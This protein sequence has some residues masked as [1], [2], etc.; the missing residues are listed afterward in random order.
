MAHRYK[1][2]DIAQ[3]SGL[4][5]ATVDR[6]LNG[7]A[8]VRESTRAE[9]MQAI[10]DLD[11]QRSQLRLNGQRY[12]ID[13]VMEAPGRFS[14]AFRAAV[15][16]ELP[17]FAPA[18]LR[19]RFHLWEHGPPARMV[20]TLGR[21]RASH[22]VVLKAR[23]EPVVAEAIDAL[24]ASGVPVVTYTT[25]VPNSCRCAYVGIDNRAAG[26]TA[27][28]LVQQ[29][30]GPAPSDVL[31]ILSRNASRGEEE[32]EAGFRTG[33][34]G[35]GRDI[36]SVSDAG[37]SVNHDLLRLLEER[38]SLQAVYSI[39]G[40]NAATLAAFERLGLRCRVF[41]AHDLDA[42][43]R[44]LLRAGRISAVL[45]NDLCVDAR[46]AMQLILQAR[47]VLSAE[48]ARPTPVQIVCPHNLP[49]DR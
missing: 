41:V 6:V 26:V 4:S 9:V 25:D 38:P 10:A 48:P 7:R 23:D 19:A 3:Q 36:V 42:D 39:G 49:A 22:G 2:R 17:T 33:L 37:G 1:I 27:A 28:Y 8:G 20:E 14:D 35:S 12:L 15:E 31:V 24:A 44:R 18:V 34:R 45:H 21:I 47:G 5:K 16:Y 30:L 43:N 29:W 13:V 11:K 32:R 40:G 46:K